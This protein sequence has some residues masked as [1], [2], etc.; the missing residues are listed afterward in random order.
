MH[1]LS[2]ERLSIRKRHLSFSY[3]SYFGR[4]LSTVQLRTGR[5]IRKVGLINGGSMTL[6]EGLL[7]ISARVAQRE[8]M[9]SFIN[10]AFETTMENAEWS[11]K[12]LMKSNL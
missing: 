9:A 5:G 2:V 12:G 3:L 6:L 10:G 8:L 11:K 4:F 1:V 7:F